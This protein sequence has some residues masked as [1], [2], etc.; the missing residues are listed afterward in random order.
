LN[1]SS[2]GKQEPPNKSDLVLAL[3]PQVFEWA[4]AAKPRQPL[5][6]G[7]W[8]GDWSLDKASPTARV[9]LAQSDVISFH[10]YETGD[11]FT[12]RIESLEKYGRPLLCTEY[13][14]RGNNS[15][16]E[17]ILPIAK[18]DN[19]AAY[20]WGFVQGK[21][22]TNMPWDSWQHPYTDREP[23]MW[24]HDIFYPD[25]RPYKPE[26]AEFIRRETGRAKPSGM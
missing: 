23:A 8:Q 3:L 6:S 14:A 17:G 2:Y 21:T 24:F 15:T 16:F 7:V 22:Q 20:N 18:K 26:E 13:M 9:Q 11:K 25:G 5:T 10:N 12:A 19:V 4:R 1:N